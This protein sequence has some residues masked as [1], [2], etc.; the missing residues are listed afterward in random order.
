[1]AAAVVVV[2]A[3][4]APLFTSP[5]LALQ[6]PQAVVVVAVLL[7]WVVVPVVQL[8]AAMA[9][10]MVAV[11]SKLLRATSCSSSSIRPMMLVLRRRRMM[12]TAR[13]KASNRITTNRGLQTVKTKARARARARARATPSRDRKDPVHLRRRVL[14]RTSRGLD[15]TSRASASPVDRATKRVYSVSDMLEDNNN[16]MIIQEYTL[17]GWMTRLGCIGLFFV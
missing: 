1:M 4:V 5:T 16:N 6:V 8:G 2:A 14:G 12:W 3:T 9:I 11:V 13:V 7:V 10:A 15:L 17:G